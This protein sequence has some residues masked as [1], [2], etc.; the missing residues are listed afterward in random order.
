ML[1]IDF[2][3]WP[4]GVLWL[5][6]INFLV[7]L[8][9]LNVVAYRPIRGILDK[10]AEEMAGMQQKAESYLERYG[11]NEKTLQENIVQARREGFNIREG[12]KQDGVSQE[13]GMVQDASSKTSE[14]LGKARQEI[15]GN[16]AGVRQALQ[17]EVDRFS[18]E[19]AEKILGRSF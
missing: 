8:I 11:E 1:E 2:N 10:R 17:G 14:Q 7:L 13:K 9:V 12:I 5:Q 4:P 6:I 15:E 18:Q 3:L 19:L 16:V